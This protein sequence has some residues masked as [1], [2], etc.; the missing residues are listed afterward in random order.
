MINDKLMINGKRISGED[1]IIAFLQEK[2]FSCNIEDYSLEVEFSA[3]RNAFIGWLNGDDEIYYYDNG[4]GNT[5]SVALLINVC[6]EERM[7]CYDRNVLKEIVLYFCES[8]LRHPGYK[9]I[10]DEF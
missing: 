3:E 8:G 5:D 9:W 1:D 4:S 10:K 7:M 6:P 2:H